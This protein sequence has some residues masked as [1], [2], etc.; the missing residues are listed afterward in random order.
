MQLTEFLTEEQLNE[1]GL[2]KNLAGA[3]SGGIA[4]AKA[5]WQQ[6]KGK[7][8]VDKMAAHH[9]NKL[10]QQSGGGGS[11]NGQIDPADVNSYLQSYG[12]DTNSVPALQSGNAN[13]VKGYITNVVQKNYPKILAAQQN[14]TLPDAP[15]AATLPPAQAN[16]P[17]PAANTPSPSFGQGGYNS[18]NMPAASNNNPTTTQTATVPPTKAGN[19][20]AQAATANANNFADKRAN[21]AALAQANMTSNP[22]PVNAPA[23][24]TPASVRAAKQTVAGSNARASMTDVP[25]KEPPG[26]TPADI[27]AQRRSERVNAARAAAQKSM[28]QPTSW[29]TKRAAAAQ[30]AQD[31][32][33]TNAIPK[34]QPTAAPAGASYAQQP[35]FTWGNANTK[36]NAPTGVPPVNNPQPT[37]RPRPANTAAVNRPALQNKGRTVGAETVPFREK[38]RAVRG[39]RALPPQ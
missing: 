8:A 9:Y 10:L 14:R 34:P 5:G 1:L 6:A 30:A 13:A 11:A 15:H 7:A 22:T 32:M 4:G 23:G 27:A 19:W 3:V 18:V 35:N 29:E 24:P 2:L 21:A 31:N 26:P 25:P 36:V 28:S 38:G 37:P 33:A 16:T 39:R 17:T 20:A 12:L